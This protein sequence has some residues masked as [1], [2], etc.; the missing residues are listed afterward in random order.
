MNNIKNI[1]EIGSEFW[2]APRDMM[3]NGDTLPTCLTDKFPV[4]NH[5]IM[6]STGRNACSLLLQH[7][8]PKKK[9]VLL[10][11]YTGG[12]VIA[13]FV[14][15]GYAL[16][17]YQVD[18]DLGLDM[19]Q[20]R[21]QYQDTQ[22]GVVLLHSYFGF[23]TLACLREKYEAIQSD[24]SIV[25]EDVTHSLLSRFPL[26]CCP[27]YYLG[28]IRKWL[29]IPDGGFLLDCSESGRISAPDASDDVFVKTRVEAFL[30]KHSYM[31]DGNFG[32]KEQARLLLAKAEEHLDNTLTP[33][34][35]SAVSRKILAKTDW[36]FIYH[37]RRGN[38]LFLEKEL[39]KF[40]LL[41]PVFHSLPNDVCPLFMPIWVDENHRQKL[42]D[43]LVK[44]DV[45]TPIHWPLPKYVS[46]NQT[47]LLNGIYGH[48]LSIP[49][50]QR[51]N[52]S[53]ML[54]IIDVLEKYF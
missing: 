48:G 25:I 16:H 42:K 36:N 27:D 7:L 12:S 15:A 44:N 52:E 29:G 54:R 23:D 21:H 20:W 1:N 18:H 40:S 19:D 47:R 49:C 34:G 46:E 41:H 11:E 22:P 51:Y 43:H 13:P 2:F 17:F 9:S 33:F 32:K 39:Q 8:Q 6:T 24:G 30:L 45:Y 31:N 4:S 3:G 37:Q 50:D 26:T 35:I 28:S 14:N 38:Y 10:P 5:L 53:H